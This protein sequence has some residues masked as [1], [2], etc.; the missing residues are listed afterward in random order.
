MLYRLKTCKSDNDKFA[1]SAQNNFSR[2][3][4]YTGVDMTTSLPLNLQRT[5]L[6]IIPVFA[7]TVNKSKNENLIET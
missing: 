1:K 7:M 4:T 6:L 5:Q 2:F 3:V